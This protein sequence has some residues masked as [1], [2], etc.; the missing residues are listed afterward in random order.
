[1]SLKENLRKRVLTVGSWITLG[2]P[3]VA[4]IMARAGFDWLTIDLEHSAISLDQAQHLI[5]VIELSGVTPLVRVGENNPYLIKRVMDAGA[6]GVIVPMVNTAEEA[7]R[8]VDAVKY[9]PEGRRGVGLG[10]AQGYGFEFER[11][12]D[13]AREESILI[14]Q[15]EH[16]DAIHNLSEILAVDG[17]D[18]S[19]VGP[20][21]LSG[22]I[23]VPGDFKNPTMRR[24]L[25]TYE[26]VS[27]QL[28]KAKGFHIVHP[29]RKTIMAYRKKGYRFL[30]LGIDTLFLGTGCRKIVKEF[31]A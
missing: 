4:E 29:E 3:A 8:A 7:R 22:S 25:H 5:Q 9:P 11:Y 19:I 2:H 14:L 10:R 30:A 13:W 21:D 6:H 20:Y 16:I 31:R 27:T 23:G 12:R 24:V 26:L 17:V 28:G 18:G 1:M 15:I